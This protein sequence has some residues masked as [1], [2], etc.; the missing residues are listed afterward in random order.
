MSD[1][2]TENTVCELL[3][4]VSRRQNLDSR[5]RSHP[6]GDKRPQKCPIL[7]GAPVPNRDS[8]S[9]RF[10]AVIWVQSIVYFGDL[11]GAILLNYTTWWQT[12]NPLMVRRLP[13][14]LPYTIT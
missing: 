3:Y 13:I 12:G 6:F 8:A 11:Q 14:I 2:L 9:S 7:V 5:R 4:V 10:S 1:L